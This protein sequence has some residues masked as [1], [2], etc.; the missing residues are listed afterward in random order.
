MVLYLISAASSWRSTTHAG[1]MGVFVGP[2]FTYNR[3]V[4]LSGP[5]MTN[6]VAGLEAAILALRLTMQIFLRKAL[7]SGLHQVVIKTDLDYL[8]KAMMEYVFI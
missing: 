1:A 6:Q 8:F 7:G 4:M 3:S 2:E 5:N